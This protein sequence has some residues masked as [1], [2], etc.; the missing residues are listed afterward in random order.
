MLMYINKCKSIP[1][2]RA[3]RQSRAQK[4]CSKCRTVPWIKFWR[5]EKLVTVWLEKSVK[6]LS[7]SWSK[8]EIFCMFVNCHDWNNPRLYTENKKMS[9]IS[10]VSSMPIPKLKNWAS[11]PCLRI[12]YWRDNPI[13]R[14]NLIQNMLML[15]IQII[16]ATAIVKFLWSSERHFSAIWRH[17]Q[18]Y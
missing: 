8:R 7:T 11:T 4:G 13:S 2:K 6:H 9:G 17:L 10:S 3:N 1:T 14:S 16:R 18:Q 15:T 12:H 5:T